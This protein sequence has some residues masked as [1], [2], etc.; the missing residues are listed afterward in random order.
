MLPYLFQGPHLY[1]EDAYREYCWSVDAYSAYQP[2]SFIYLC[3]ESFREFM[4]S[5]QIR[6]DEK[7]QR[8]SLPKRD[9]HSIP[10]K[11]LR[12]AWDRN[13]FFGLCTRICTNHDVGLIEEHL[14]QSR[15]VLALLPNEITSLHGYM[16]GIDDA[17]GVELMLERLGI[18]RF[19]KRLRNELMYK[20]E[21]WWEEVQVPAG[22]LFVS[23]DGFLSDGYF[24]DNY[25]YSELNYEKIV[26]LGSTYSIQ[27]NNLLLATYESP[28]QTWLCHEPLTINIRL[29]NFGPDLANVRVSFVVNAAYEACASLEFNLPPMQTSA[30]V[31]LT[32]QVIPRCVGTARPIE[33]LRAWSKQ[34]EV[35]IHAELPIVI[36][37]GSIR[38]AALSSAPQDTN[39]LS[40][41]T[42]IMS[43]TPVSNDLQ[44]IIA[45]SVVDLDAC[46]NKIRKT[47]ETLAF[48]TLQ[49][50]KAVKKRLTFS[51]CIHELRASGRLSERAVGYL[52][53]IRVVGNLASH[54]S[55]VP[56]SDRDVRVAAYALASIIEEL[57]ERELL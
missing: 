57:L 8:V 2:A 24:F 43:K 9:I 38:A 33:K 53:T 12:N 34:N 56:M 41:L 54:P 27:R 51:D 11:I 47:A 44:K 50:I 13:L 48:S 7:V 35:E 19:S 46:L 25:G 5:R 29:R 30:E 40:F 21:I 20:G 17:C 18:S 6:L 36:I 55:E 10:T 45:L 37:S 52:H 23:E 28:P 4:Q 39:N 22:R 3:F 32:T 31:T 42:E 14:T 15:N 26:E 1:R 49:Q 16:R